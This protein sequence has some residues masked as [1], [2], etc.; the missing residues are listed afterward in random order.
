MLFASGSEHVHFSYKRY[1]ENRLR[2]AFGFGGTPL[3][4]I[5]RERSRSELETRPRKRAAS[6]GTKVRVKGKAGGKPR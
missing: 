2:D 5:V 6:R 1:L 3:R 4:L